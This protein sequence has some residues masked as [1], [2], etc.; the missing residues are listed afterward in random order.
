MKR[1]YLIV[2][3]GTLTFMGLIFMVAPNAYFAELRGIA[4]N[5]GLSETLRG[6]GGFYLGFAAWLAWALFKGKS[7]DAAIQSIV[8]VMSGILA[9]RLVGI[10]T[11]GI[12]DQK[13][14]ASAGIELFFAL[15]GAA[16]IA[17]TKG[18]K[19]NGPARQSH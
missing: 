2:V 1:T 17:K 5:S 8:I 14:I 10:I 16:L 9:G 12:P 6:F 11:D 3:A 7:I 19:S 15:W 4:D 18:G 13:F